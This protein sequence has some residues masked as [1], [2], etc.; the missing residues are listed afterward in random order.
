MGWD[1]EITT[2]GRGALSAEFGGEVCN[3]E[4]SVLSEHSLSS[5]G[6]SF[7]PG[8]ISL[9]SGIGQTC[10]AGYHVVMVSMVSLVAVMVMLILVS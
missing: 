1:H 3:E 5:R 9:T 2:T 10:R 6:S 7:C 4:G 8:L